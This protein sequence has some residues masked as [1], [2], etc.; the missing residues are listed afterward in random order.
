MLYIFLENVMRFFL[1]LMMLVGALEAKIGDSRISVF[2]GYRSDGL[3]WRS[4]F[5]GSSA[6][7]TKENWSGLQIA[8][9]G[10]RLETSFFD[11]WYLSAEGDYGW[12]LRGS[13]SFDLDYA[14]IEIDE[15]LKAKSRGQVY[16]VSCEMGYL[17]QFFG[18]QFELMPLLGFSYS[19]Q[20]FIDRDYKDLIYLLNV[21]DEVNSE[22]TYQ[23][24][25]PW[26][27]LDFAYLFKGYEIAF[28]Y[29]GHLSFYRGWNQ[30][31]LFDSYK[32][33]TKKN[34][35][36]G[37]EFILKL[38]FPEWRR[39]FF[40]FEGG[41]LFYYGC[42]GKSKIGGQQG[43]LERISWSSGSILVSATRSF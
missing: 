14:T 24:F 37:N 38:I 22:S 17:A 39:W 2:T 33:R 25:G 23:W 36:F 3:E 11:H 13:K 8:E 20:H 5:E 35:A 43:K 1:L 7:K 41:Y 32:E 31:N 30:D 16:D 4:R 26:A 29:E 27:G 18:G 6:Y 15:W 40:G 19:V 28:K 34:N 10:G 21:F 42:D 12:I 9:V